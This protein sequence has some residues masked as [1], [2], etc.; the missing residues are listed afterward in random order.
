MKIYKIFLKR[1]HIELQK[2]V[3]IYNIIESSNIPF[4]TPKNVYFNLHLD[5]VVRLRLL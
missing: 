4:L 2:I 3:K 1:K 5:S